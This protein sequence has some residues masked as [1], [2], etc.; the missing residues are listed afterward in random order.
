MFYMD[1]IKEVVEVINTGPG[2][3]AGSGFSSRLFQFL[4]V[5]VVFT[6]C[7]SGQGDPSGL[8]VA[9]RSA[10]PGLSLVFTYHPHSPRA[11]DSLP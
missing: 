8:S 11:C 7:V 6:V 5:K 3:T 1:G 10:L 2:G 4:C 9:V